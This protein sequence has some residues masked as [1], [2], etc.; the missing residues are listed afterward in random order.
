MRFLVKFIIGCGVLLFG[1][2]GMAS[3]SSTSSNGSIEVQKDHAAEVMD[4][5]D[6][7]QSFDSSSDCPVDGEDATQMD[8]SQ[9][10]FQCWDCE[11]NC[12]NDKNCKQMC[13]NIN[14]ACCTAGGKKPTSPW[15]CGCVG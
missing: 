5:L 4:V 6:S 3:T 13:W 11:K 15:G 8:T 10:I 7:S 1:I 9:C 12:N 14:S 2:M